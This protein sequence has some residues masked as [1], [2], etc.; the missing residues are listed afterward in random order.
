MRIGFVMLVHQALDRAAQVAR[1]WA[2]RGCPVVIHV[3]RSVKAAEAARLRGLVAD[4]AGQVVFC[5]RYRCEW[6]MFSI[7]R[8][9]LAGSEMMLARFP[10]V[11]RVYLASGSCM[12]LRPVDELAAYL[13][14]HPDTDFIESVR[15][16][17]VRWA[18]GGLDQERFTLH[19]PF[20][21]RSQRWLFDRSVDL[22]RR[23]GVQRRLPKGVAPHLGSQWWCL[24]RQTLSAILNDPDRPVFDRFFRSVWIPDEAYF[25]SLARRHARRIESRSL[26]LSKFDFQGKPHVFYDDHLALLER[27]DC[28]VA[29]KIW[30]RAEKLYEAFLND[31]RMSARRTVPNPRRVDRVF[32]RANE[33]RTKGRTG[34]LMQSRFPASGWRKSYTAAPYSVFEGFA[35]VME[36]FPLWLERRT[37]ARVHGHLF[38]RTRVEFAA[39]A[40]CFA[41]ALSD[42][43]RLR[44]YNP[45]A[46][47]TSLVWN[48]Q[49]THQCFQFGPADTQDAAWFFSSD[50]NAHVTVITGAWLVPLYRSSLNF[51]RV[52]KIAARYQRIELAHLEVIRSHEARA[53]VEIMSLSEF[54]D[55]PMQVMQDIVD[56]LNPISGR[57][58]LEAPVFADL[59]GFGTFMQRLRNQGMNPHLAGDFALME[60]P[61]DEEAADPLRAALR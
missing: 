46:F 42:R 38:D 30:P 48:S 14:R 18:V 28:F 58:L 29:R 52:L 37:G 32:Q 60:L 34:L 39:G 45:R 54:F 22:Q 36:D 25:Q 19:F 31:V 23:M 57:K 7:V 16:E 6:G 55:D 35:E 27:S 24:T 26:T 4:L 17:D 40:T 61:S 53:R 1:Y 21:W 11:E 10:E 43:P 3:D 56:R 41:G 2:M 50:P 47:L 13:E 59:S 51:E 12:P 9:T 44:D 33:R 8:A 49:G 5:P 20:S 15:T